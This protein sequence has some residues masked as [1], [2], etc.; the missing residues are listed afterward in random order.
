MK[1]Y[2]AL[3]PQAHVKI[4]SVKCKVWFNC[5]IIFNIIFVQISESVL[6]YLEPYQNFQHPKLNINPKFESLII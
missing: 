5:I 2:V 6:F 4:N 1:M 3:E